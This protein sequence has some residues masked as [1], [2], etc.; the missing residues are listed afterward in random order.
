MTGEYIKSR[1]LYSEAFQNFLSQMAR[2]RLE[3]T[4]CARHCRPS[5]LFCL[6]QM[7]ES[8]ENKGY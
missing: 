3:R 5:G 1:F 8:D 2:G 4:L 7:L 6:R